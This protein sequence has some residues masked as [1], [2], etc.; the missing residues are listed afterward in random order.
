MTEGNKHLIQENLGTGIEPVLDSHRGER[1]VVV[2]QDFPD[3]DAISSAYAHKLISAEYE[4]EVDILYSGK[5]SLPENLALVKLLEMD[6]TSFSEGLDLSHYKGVVYVDNQSTTAKRIARSLKA[7]N[8]PTLIV[9]D[10]H[11][12]Q[13]ENG[14]AF[15]DIRKTGATA[16]ICTRYL[17]QGLLEL[18]KANRRHVLAATALMHGIT[19]RHEPFHPGGEFL[20]SLPERRAAQTDH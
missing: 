13:I 6:L 4:I 15:Q 3:P 12:V 2:I 18:E 11:E 17:Q 9:V 8:V 14:A 16:T 5:I 19:D 1:H 10:H 20:E 7:A